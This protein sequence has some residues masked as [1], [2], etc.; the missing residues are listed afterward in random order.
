MTPRSHA[1][2][3]LMRAASDRARTDPVT[4]A[5]TRTSLAD[6]RTALCLAIGVPVDKIGPLG[7]YMSRQR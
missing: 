5:D 2:Q 3:G 4:Y 6:W 7:H 1:T